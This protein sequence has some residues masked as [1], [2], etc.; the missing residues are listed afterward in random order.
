MFILMTHIVNKNQM[1][2]RISQIR[3]L[4]KEQDIEIVLQY[5][6]MPYLQRLLMMITIDTHGSPKN[7]LITFNE[8]KK[9]SKIDIDTIS[10]TFQKRIKIKSYDTLD[11]IQHIM[12]I[13]KMI[14]ITQN[15]KK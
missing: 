4:N 5:M 7:Q 12:Y 6:K 2:Y 11:V 10:K 13:S 8:S 9:V 15:K 1:L 14:Q 3:L